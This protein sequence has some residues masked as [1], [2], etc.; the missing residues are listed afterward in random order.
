MDYL[1]A[2]QAQLL[3]WGFWMGSLLLM[4]L[5]DGFGWLLIGTAGALGAS[6]MLNTSMGLIVPAMGIGHSVFLVNFLFF[7][8]GI[9][10]SIGQSV[11]G[12]RAKTFE[13]WQAA[14]WVL[15]CIGVVSVAGIL[16]GR[17]PRAERVKQSDSPPDRCD[18]RMLLMIGIFG[19][20]FIAEHGMLN[21]FVSYAVSYLQMEQGAA[22]NF[23]AL[24]SAGIMMGRLLFGPLVDRFGVKKA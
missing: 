10:T 9:G 15:L 20:Y 13:D 2:G 24:F 21:W 5:T 7:I 19:L 1:Q 12:N 16:G 8:Q 23:L 22:A 17:Y 14:L 6:T 3:F 18:R 11:L 4:A